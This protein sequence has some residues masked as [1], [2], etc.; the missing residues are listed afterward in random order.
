MNSSL[1]YPIYDS[2][3]EPFNLAEYLLNSIP[4]KHHY[5]IAYIDDD[6]VVSYGELID[7]VK[8]FATYLTQKN[9]R[10]EDRVA[11]LLPDCVEFVYAYLGIIWLGGVAVIINESYEQHHIDYIIESSRL[12]YVITT[13][14]HREA[15][16]KKLAENNRFI[17]VND[18]LASHVSLLPQ[19]SKAV[20]CAKEEPAFWVFSSGSTSKPKGVIHAHYNPVVA[21]CNYGKHILKLTTEDVVLSAPPMGF[22]YGLGTSIYFPLV[23]Q[24]TVI[25]SKSKRAFELIKMINTHQV[26]VLFGVPYTYASIHALHE[27]SPLQCQSLRLCVSAGERLPQAVLQKWQKDYRLTICEGVGTSESTHIFLSN[28]DN[29]CV[30]GAS[31]KCVPG[32]QARVIDESGNTVENG[33]VGRLEV[34][35]EGFMLGYWNNLK[36]TQQTIVGQRYMPGDLFKTDAEGNFYFVGRDDGLIKHK[37]MWLYPS[38]IE[39][40][41]SQ[42]PDVDEAVV[43]FSRGLI[44]DVAEIFA[45]VKARKNVQHT[46]GLLVDI[47]K[48]L[49]EKLSKFK[50][51]R[52]I[53]LV[54]QFPRT[55]TGKID[56]NALSQQLQQQERENETC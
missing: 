30:I 28:I 12:T 17:L 29:E 39:R 31:G 35:G 37:G 51:P 14:E 38:E 24:S 19:H 7:N 48:S 41:I 5:S 43:L 8:R 32:Y 4:E 26:T 9:I 23:K 20:L 46:K 16:D 42:H 47:K 49:Q 18:E 34:T 1:T 56:R 53:N 50:V 13:S 52:H 2:L 27:I 21:I 36:A 44:A 22:S 55:A 11:I 33:N 54:D 40:A 45:F 10:R 25:L 3:P 15:I 6:N